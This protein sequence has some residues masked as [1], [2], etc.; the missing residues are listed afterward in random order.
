MLCWSHYKFWRLI[1]N[2][3]L[4]INCKVIEC[5]ESYTCKTCGYCG[6][7]NDKFGGSKVFKS[8]L[9]NCQQKFI[10]NDRNIHTTR[11]ILLYYI[12]RNN[13]LIQ[14]VF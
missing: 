13:I 9:E 12:T 5:D 3:E 2:S 1:H 10:S 14:I 4:F 7:I 8:K 6:I 11:N